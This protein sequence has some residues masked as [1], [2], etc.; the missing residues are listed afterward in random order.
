[1]SHAHDKPF[2]LPADQINIPAGSLWRKMPIIGLVLGAAGIGGAWASSSGDT[3][4]FWYAYLVGYMF[5]LA[6]GLGGL[7]FVIIQHLVR[8]GWSIAVRRIAENAMI[9]L[10]VLCVLGLPII[11]LG[12][13]DLYHWTDTEAVAAD[14]MLNAKKSYLN[15]GS[16]RLRMFVYFGVWTVL[17]LFFYGKST[18][19]DGNPEAGVAAAH[20]MRFWAAPAL[21]L[22]ALSLTFAAFDLLMSL[23][24]HWFSTMFGVYYFAGA[25]LSQFAF[26]TLVAIL[27]HK[28][29]YL[30]GVVTTEH[31]H[32][33][34]KFLFGFTVFY[35]YI[36][37]SQYFL[38]WYANIPEETMWFGYRIADDFLPLTFLLCIGRFFLPFFFLLRRGVKRNTFTLTLA[39]VWILFMEVVDMFW[40]IQPV[41]AHHHA[42]HSG[43]HTMHMHIGPVDILALLG[44]VGVFVAVFTWACGRKA[45]VPTADPRIEESVKFEN[46]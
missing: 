42:L 24:P 37:F 25:A 3:G 28:S 17:S 26:I 13:H 2:V 22:Y 8:A 18:G 12:A 33:L 30:R 10:P 41:R 44:V 4:A 6:L 35:T 27:L 23:D 29:G 43:D 14:F 19:S 39:A 20:K 36:A 40:L 15:E 21:F 31:Y 5:C 46:F 34:G 9:T 32:D 7:F 16:F 38:I 45:L 1:M 11:F